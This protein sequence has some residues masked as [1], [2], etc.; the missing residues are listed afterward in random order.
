MRQAKCSSHSQSAITCATSVLTHQGRFPYVI[1]QLMQVHAVGYRTQGMPV[2]NKIN[3]L[4]I[5]MQD[6]KFLALG[7]EIGPA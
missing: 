6:R 4:V 5:L 1:S 2:Q 3:S 7:Q